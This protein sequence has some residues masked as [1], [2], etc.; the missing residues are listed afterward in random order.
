[1]KLSDEK[2]FK[3]QTPE[4]GAQ[5]HRGT[6]NKYKAFLHVE[7]Y[8]FFFSVAQQLYER[9][10]KKVKDPLSDQHALTNNFKYNWCIGESIK[11]F[12]CDLK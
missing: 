5:D 2:E 3:R 7:N 9:S 11:H 10:H 6:V 4:K 12:Y 1:M 8:S